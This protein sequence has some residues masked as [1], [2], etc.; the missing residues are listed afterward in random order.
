M[1]HIHMYVSQNVRLNT[2]NEELAT[3]V[4]DLKRERAAAEGT[5]R[6][7]QP[8]DLQTIM[9]ESVNNNLRPYQ[10]VDD[11][12]SDSESDSELRCSCWGVLSSCG[13]GSGS[14]SAISGGSIAVH[15]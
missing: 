7:L 11:S 1:I 14:F 8:G 3:S 4:M 6:P 2:K 5:S 13:A 9:E 10:D 15:H 12:E